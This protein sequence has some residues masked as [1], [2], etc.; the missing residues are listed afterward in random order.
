MKAKDVDIKT[1][2]T[3][4]SKVAGEFMCNLWASYNTCHQRHYIHC[5]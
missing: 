5:I 3:G 1:D 2:S 4:I